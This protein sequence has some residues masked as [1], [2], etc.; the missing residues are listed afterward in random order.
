M[1]K[2]QYGIIGFVTGILLGLLIGIIEM[3][4]MK[5]LQCETFM[6]FVIGITVIASAVTGVVTAI[7]LSRRF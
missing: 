4:L 1:K 5:R 7:K 6:P 3:K 2:I